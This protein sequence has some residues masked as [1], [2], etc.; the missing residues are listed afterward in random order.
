M[1]R[2]I[3]FRVYA[4]FPAPRSFPWPLSACNL[5][6]HR[7]LGQVYHTRLQGGRFSDGM[8][9]GQSPPSSPRNPASGPLTPPGFAPAPPPLTSKGAALDPEPDVPSPDSTAARLGAVHTPGKLAA[10][11][12]ARDA[13]ALSRG[14]GRRRSGRK[15]SRYGTPGSRPQQQRDVSAK[16]REMQRTMFLKLANEEFDEQ[17][18]MARDEARVRRQQAAADDHEVR[19]RS[20]V[21]GWAGLELAARGDAGA[22]PHPR[23]LRRS[24]RRDKSGVERAVSNVGGS[25]TLLVLPVPSAHRIWYTPRERSCVGPATGPTQAPSCPFAWTASQCR[26]EDG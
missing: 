16:K 13:G 19:R 1:R 7:L 8:E 18:N 20:G 4:H 23:S 15:P 9:V 14:T 26:Q 11:R 2:E 25:G 22:F 21:G 17:Q 24:G 5:E 3:A 6:C 10:K 12:T